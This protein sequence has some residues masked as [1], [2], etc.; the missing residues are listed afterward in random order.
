MMLSIKFR[1]HLEEN[2][3]NNRYPKRSEMKKARLNRHWLSSQQVLLL[4]KQELTPEVEGARTRGRHLL[5]QVFRH[6]DLAETAYF[7]LRFQD[8]A[9]QTVRLNEMRDER[10][11]LF[12]KMLSLF[13][14]SALARPVQARQLPAQSLLSG[15][16]VLRGQ[17]LRRGP[18]QAHRRD[19]QIPVLPAG[20][21]GPDVAMVII[22]VDNVRPPI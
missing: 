10:A 13:P 12:I 8:G 1:R 4:D 5:E 18:L 9:G 6:L 15:D 21:L 2:F 19:H 7:G 3:T 17:V 20:I 16:P 11:I 14:P 22:D